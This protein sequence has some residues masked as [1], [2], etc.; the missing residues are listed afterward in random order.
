MAFDCPAPKSLAQPSS[1][2]RWP[3]M[4]E[5][6]IWEP[7]AALRNALRLICRGLQQ[8]NG[9]ALPKAEQPPQADQFS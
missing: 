1:K 5:K 6:G 7:D 8:T 4:D 2:R 9:K 3:R